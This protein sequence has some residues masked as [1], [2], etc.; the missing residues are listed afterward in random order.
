MIGN[1]KRVNRPVR[2]WRATLPA[3]CTAGERGTCEL[4][5]G[6]P[7]WP[8]TIT[9]QAVTVLRAGKASGR[10]T[11]PQ[12]IV[13]RD[14]TKGRVVRIPF[15]APARTGEH[16]LCVLI[17]GVHVTGSP[18]PLVVHAGR[19]A[20]HM[21]SLVGM[22]GGALR[23]ACAGIAG[24]PIRFGVAL[25]DR[26]GNRCDPAH[27]S[28]ALAHVR[29]VVSLR[30]GEGSYLPTEPASLPCERCD[31]SVDLAKGKAGL[32]AVS[33]VRWRAGTYEARLALGDEPIPGAM[34]VHVA[35]PPKALRPSS[36]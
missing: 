20:A 33:I 21:C 4:H 2:T 16:M 8:A 25:A 9:V 31:V 6:Q 23:A 22:A 1:L 18:L 26:H 34:A 15:P 24:E 27:A 12:S 28:E 30:E 7:T 3:P 32:L 13:L 11:P 35:K 36:K 5:V 10:A 17:N 14:A 19:P 29:T